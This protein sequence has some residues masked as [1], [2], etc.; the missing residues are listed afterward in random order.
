[1]FFLF[2]IFIE[3]DKGRRKKEMRSEKKI[4]LS[5]W[6]CILGIW[7]SA[8]YWEK[9]LRL[10]GLTF[11]LYWALKFFGSNQQYYRSHELKV[12]CMAEPK[13]DSHDKKFGYLNQKMLTF[14]KNQTFFLSAE[15]SFLQTNMKKRSRFGVLALLLSGR[16][17]EAELK[18][19]QSRWLTSPSI[20]KFEMHR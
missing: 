5:K 3:Q 16:T 13:F 18:R 4:F 12:A 17:R 11:S 7:K 2:S 15:N 19:F 14:N 1:M 10:Q 6:E 20:F 9:K 8:T